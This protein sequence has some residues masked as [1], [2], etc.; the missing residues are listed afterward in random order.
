MA[1]KDDRWK[2]I[3]ILAKVTEALA[4]AAVAIVAVLAFVF[5]PH[6]SNVDHPPQLPPDTVKIP[7]VV[8]PKKPNDTSEVPVLVERTGNRGKTDNHQH[9]GDSAKL[10]SGSGTIE[11]TLTQPQNAQDIRI[12][13]SD[14]TIRSTLKN[15]IGNIAIFKYF[16]TVEDHHDTGQTINLTIYGKDK[17]QPVLANVANNDLIH[18]S[19]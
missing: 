18:I 14:C 1:T 19:L 17:K 13:C 5:T 16:F 9:T 11:V 4:A 15:T 8:N 12:T 10:L 7:A 2:F 6:S 3:E